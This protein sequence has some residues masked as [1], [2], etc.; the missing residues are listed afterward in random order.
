MGAHLLE[1][2]VYDAL[3][4]LP[5]EDEDVVGAPLA[6]LDA[7]GLLPDVV[8]QDL[9]LYVVGVVYADLPDQQP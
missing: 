3:G 2:H 8:G 9:G 6:H 4:V 7:E 1:H 5:V